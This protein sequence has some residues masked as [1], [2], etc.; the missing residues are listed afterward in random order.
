MGS[1]KPTKIWSFNKDQDVIRDKTCLF[2]LEIKY[3]CNGLSTGQLAVIVQNAFDRCLKWPLWLCNGQRGDDEFDDDDCSSKN[4]LF[5]GDH[6][7]L[8]FQ[9]DEQNGNSL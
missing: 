4:A 8:K 5:E 7:Q 2:E 1:G 3:G 9:T 6:L